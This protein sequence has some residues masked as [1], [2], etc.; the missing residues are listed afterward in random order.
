LTGALRALEELDRRWFETAQNEYTTASK[1][2]SDRADAA[3][4]KLEREIKAIFAR[5]VQPLLSGAG[6]A[7]SKSADFAEQVSASAWE[8]ISTSSSEELFQ[9]GPA[10]KEPGPRGPD[11]HRLTPREIDRQ[12][13]PSYS[14]NGA[15]PTELSGTLLDPERI[16]RSVQAARGQ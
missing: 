10:P 1:A 13:R 9:L 15:P 12:W 8:S 11:G 2:I 6:M 4:L 5:H 7:A 14:F 3:F 16:E